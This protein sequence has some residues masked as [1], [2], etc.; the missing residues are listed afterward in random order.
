MDEGYESFTH[1]LWK[2]E[3]PHRD[4]MYTDF[5][6]PVL[7]KE[8]R[9]FVVDRL[10]E[11]QNEQVKKNDD[12]SLRC[13]KLGARQFRKRKWREATEL[14]NIGVCTAE[15]GSANLRLAY[16]AR[17]N[18]FTH[19][20]MTEEANNDI[21]LSSEPPAKKSKRSSDRIRK[22]EPSITTQVQRLFIPN[23]KFPNLANALDVQYNEKF[24]RHVVSFT[25]TCKCGNAPQL[26]KHSHFRW[27]S[28]TFLLAKR[29]Q[30][31]DTLLALCVQ[32]TN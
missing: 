8:F 23:K 9:K 32:Q 5:Y 11:A 29:L 26:N 14:Y 20:R 24:G 28:V 31:I 13:Q 3:S 6:S 30:W 17:S 21:A 2:K 25:S 22:R 27:Q 15:N 12:V 10:R 7:K 18:C 16:K 1:R 4:A 19:R